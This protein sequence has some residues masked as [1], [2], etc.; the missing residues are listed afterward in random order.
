MSIHPNIFNAQF[1]PANRYSRS[2]PIDLVGTQEP[3]TH[4]AGAHGGVVEPFPYNPSSPDPHGTATSMTGHSSEGAYN[5]RSSY[6]QMTMP[7][8]RN[9]MPGGNWGGYGGDGYATAAGIGAGAVAGAAGVGAYN[10][11]SGYPGR[12]SYGQ[13]DGQNYDY[14]SEGTSQSGDN[15]SYGAAGIG[16]GIG[17]L[18]PAAVAKQREAA[19]ERERAQGHSRQQSWGSGYGGPSYGGGSG[20]PLSPTH[21][22][23][24]ENEGGAYGGNSN[25]NASPSASGARPVS[26]AFSDGADG[27]PSSVYQHTDGGVVPE[28][29]PPK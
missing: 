4:G 11:A 1:D 9:Y 14:R 6:G 29:I 10:A 26:G 7:E 25:A 22:H 24:Y 17:A 2:D 15:S 3:F 20:Q 23:E 19:Q 13:G 18:T 21:E 16:A 28:E 8:A 5:P 27:R 12:N